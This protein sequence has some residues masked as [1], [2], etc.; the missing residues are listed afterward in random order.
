MSKLHAQHLYTRKQA[1]HG[2]WHFSRITCGEDLKKTVFCGVDK[3]G[4]EV[5]KGITDRINQQQKVYVLI[6]RCPHDNEET[7]LGVFTDKNIAKAVTEERKKIKHMYR[8]TYRI[9]EYRLDNRKG[10]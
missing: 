9:Q 6:E 5:A 10:F 8:M 7:N 1:G 3:S 4:E 2:D